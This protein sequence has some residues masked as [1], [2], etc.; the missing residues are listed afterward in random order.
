VGVTEVESVL[1]ASALE[2]ARV[3]EPARAR[4]EG[5]AA[6]A[7]VQTASASLGPLVELPQSSG[8]CGDF[9]DVF[10]AGTSEGPGHGADYVIVQSRVPSDFA[11]AEREEGGAWRAHIIP[12][13]SPTLSR[14]RV[15]PGEHIWP[16]GPRSRRTSPGL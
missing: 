9:E 5:A 7:M 11:H 13:I 4:D 3:P 10:G 6:A 1:R 16:S 8:E 14:K 2:E 15:T 12:R